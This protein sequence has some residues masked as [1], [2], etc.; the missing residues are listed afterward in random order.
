MSQ[1]GSR[2]SLGKSVWDRVDTACRQ[3]KNIGDS[4]GNLFAARSANKNPSPEQTVA[5][6]K[7]SDKI[8]V[9]VLALQG[10]YSEIARLAALT[11]CEE[12]ANLAVVRLIEAEE[13]QV[14]LIEDLARGES[15]AAPLALFGLLNTG[16]SEL[17]REI[18]VQGMI[19]G[20]LCGMVQ[21]GLT[22]AFTLL[23]FAGRN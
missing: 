2:S 12:I 10:R 11:D 19:D 9:R 21:N 17:A 5:R 4:A 3:L 15:R 7:Q 16:Y 23:A 6:A 13:D 20:S 18:F 14:N 1:S 8:L 22:T